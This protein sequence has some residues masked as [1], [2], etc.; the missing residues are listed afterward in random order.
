MKLNIQGQIFENNLAKFLANPSGGVELF[1]AD[2]R[3]DGWAKRPDETNRCI[4]QFF[5][6]V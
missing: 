4:S 6:H 5:E 1:D 2:G 3:T